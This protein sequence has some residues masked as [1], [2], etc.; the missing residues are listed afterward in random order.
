MS[1][2][3]AIAKSIIITNYEKNSS[4]TIGIPSGD[5]TSF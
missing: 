3:I 2:A 5:S 4:I 1:I